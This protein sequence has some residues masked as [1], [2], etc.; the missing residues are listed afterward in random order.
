MTTAP[1]IEIIRAADLA[2]PPPADGRET[3]E[4]IEAWC[5]AV[6]GPPPS[7]ASI[8]A[9]AGVE[10][11]ELRLAYEQGLAPERLM[12]EA[13]DTVIVLMRLFALAALD[14]RDEMRGAALTCR[15]VDRFLSVAVREMDDAWYASSFLRRPDLAAR[16]AV[17]VVTAL[18]MLCVALE[19]DLWAAVG[20]KMAVNRKRV[21][22]RE[23]GH[24][25]QLK[26]GEETHG[27]PA[28]PV[29][30]RDPEGEPS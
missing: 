13:A 19:G 16:R 11:S 12:E 21:W 4:S 25:R 1:P 7:A 17:V 18:D 15:S 20:I 6:I 14:V 28:D 27:W 26:A 5:R 22:V 9:R 30:R 8:V 29:F 10:L 3:Q 24:V 23:G 2:P